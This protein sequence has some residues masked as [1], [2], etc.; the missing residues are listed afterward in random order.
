MDSIPVLY[1]CKCTKGVLFLW[2]IFLENKKISCYQREMYGRI[3]DKCNYSEP[4][5]QNRGFTAFLLLM[6][7]SRHINLLFY[8]HASMRRKQICMALNSYKCRKGKN[9]KCLQVN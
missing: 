1:G 6:W 4:H 8:L 9:D 7:L 2:N 5:S 3:K